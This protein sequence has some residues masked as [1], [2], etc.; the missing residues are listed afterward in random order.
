MP[1]DKPPV[2][3]LGHSTR[4]LSEFIS[5]IKKYK[6]EEIADVRTIPRSR[7]NP[8]FNETHLFKFLKKH[9][10]K[11]EHM[12]GLGGLRRPNKDSPN[13]YWRNASFRGFA[14]YMQAKAFSDSLSALIK[15]AKKRNVAI[16]CAEAVPWR[17]HRSLIADALLVKG[18]KVMHI[19]ST[20]NIREH[21]MTKSAKVSKG[22]VTYP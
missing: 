4:K 21:T 18:I 22:K 5:I 13:L 12:K 9:G 1:K 3:T 19:F 20:T 15:A 14:D 11:Y 7:K 10:I 16:M 2:F 8:Q 17:C 6:I